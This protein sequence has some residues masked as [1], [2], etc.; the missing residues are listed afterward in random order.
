MK[1]L[2]LLL[3]L[4]STFFCYSQAENKE[5]IYL[6]FDT[7]SKEK[8]KVT[9]E[10]KGNVYSN[11]YRERTKGNIKEYL[12]CDETFTIRKNTISSEK[13][14]ISTIKNIKFKDIDYLLKKH[15][16]S[17]ELKHHVFKKIYLLEKISDSEIIKHD[18][19]WMDEFYL[20]D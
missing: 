3:S 15:K 8:C 19:V 5:T 9:V 7:S 14:P 4:L 16:D 2:T 17:K 18:V 13:L 6:L 1:K 20:T 10:H 12:V 11:K